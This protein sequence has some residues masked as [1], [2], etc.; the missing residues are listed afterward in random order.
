MPILRAKTT[1]EWIATLR[2]R[3][4]WCAPIHGYDQ[5]FADPAVRFLDP[6][7]EI[8]HP[9]AGRVRLLKHPIRYGAGEPEVRHLPPDI[10]EHTEEVLAE[11][12]YSPGDIERLR[13]LGAL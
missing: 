13:A 12:G 2:E 4:V 7:L 8:D 6:V 1:E 10:G 3:G 5:V 11:A 9:Q